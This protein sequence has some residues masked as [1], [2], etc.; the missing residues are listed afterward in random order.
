MA[1]GC[2]VGQDVLGAPF[3]VE[4]R[5]SIPAQVSTAHT[6]L[7]RFVCT[8]NNATLSF[9]WAGR[10]VGR[11]R[12]C[13]SGL[14]GTTFFAC[15]FSVLVLCFCVPFLCRFPL[16]PEKQL[17]ESTIPILGYL[18]AGCKTGRLH[19]ALVPADESQLRLLVHAACLICLNARSFS[20]AAQRAL[21]P[22]FSHTC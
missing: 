14:V 19:E 16:G 17:L 13:S 22:I 5:S 1:P 18:S 6:H 12:R 9:W 21:S 11:G 8:S 2:C 4:M 15:P 10:C 7:Q 20:S 3:R